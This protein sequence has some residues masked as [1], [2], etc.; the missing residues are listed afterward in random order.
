MLEEEKGEGEEMGGT[1]ERCR[2]E[3][4]AVARAWR[5][6]QAQKETALRAWDK[7]ATAEEG[8]DEARAQLET[9][10]DAAI[11]ARERVERVR[12]ESDAA[13]ERRRQNETHYGQ[14]AS[15]WKLA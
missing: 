11:R 4:A 5:G 12:D 15:F 10:V 13:V 3:M 2:V 14:N 1:A 9:C 8:L 7:A 6:A